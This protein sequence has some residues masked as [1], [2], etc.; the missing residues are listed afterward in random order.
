MR[1]CRDLL[2]LLGRSTFRKFLYQNAVWIFFISLFVACTKEENKNVRLALEWHANPNHVP[3][4][5]GKELGFFKE[6]GIDLE[7]R[8]TSDAFSIIPSLLTKKV[9]LAVYHLPNLFRSKQMS[10]LKIVGVL[11]DMPLRAFIY[12]KEHKIAS[13]KDFE[14]MRFCGNVDG[15]LTSYFR[16]LLE[17]HGVSFKEVIKVQIEPATMLIT[18]RADIIG[19]GYWNIE[20]EQLKACGIDCSYITPQDFGVPPYAELIVI[21]RENFTLSCN[22]Q[23]ALQKSIE[24][25]KKHPMH[26]FNLYVKAAPQKSMR[27]LIW[28][29][30]AWDVTYPL[31]SMTQSTDP[32]RW[33]LFYEWMKNENLMSS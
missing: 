8:Q 24:Y 6:E 17:S 23:R 18:N 28:E 4:F 9:D 27:S 26:A 7:I 13:F 15:L 25:S 12:R 22:F 33:K 21:A 14:K 30:N 3:L 31:L 5:V 11:V 2:L 32:E 10:K 1:F 20:L 16:A 19:G 29:R